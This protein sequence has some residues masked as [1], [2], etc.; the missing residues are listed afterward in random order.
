MKTIGVY[1]AVP[2]HYGGAYQ[3]NMSLIRALESLAGTFRLVAFLADEEWT[4]ML[5]ESFDQICKPRT[6]FM[7]TMEKIWRTFDCSKMRYKR[8]AAR[9][10]PVVRAINESGCDLVIFPSHDTLS[11]CT[12]K[13]SLATIHDLMHRYEG[14]F[15]EYQN[16]EYEK[17]EKLFSNMCGEVS[18]ILVDSEVG[19]IQVLESYDVEVGKVF[20]L[21]FVPPYY[22]LEGKYVDVGKKYGLPDKYLFYPAQFWEHKNHF[23]LLVAL[24]TLVD[25]GLDVNLVLAGSKKNNYEKVMDE[26]KRL[27]LKERVFVIGYVSNDEMYSLYKKA[28]ALTFV[29]MIGPTNIPPLEAML[30]GCPAIVSNVYAMPEQVEDA[31]LLVDPRDPVDIAEKIE[32]IWKDGSLREELAE[33]GLRKISSYGQDQFTSKLKNIISVVLEN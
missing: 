11:Y 6:F 8:A 25:E 1:L 2:P 18:G 7:K 17:R 23:A 3:Y 9:F 22:L 28:L 31:A 5:P 27:R 4:E 32:R 33:K 14:H 26:I 12:S 10:N 30:L 15:E 24:R 19:K 20:V 13:K 16:G 21:P 29:S